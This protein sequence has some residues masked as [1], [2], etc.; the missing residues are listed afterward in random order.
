MVNDCRNEWIN[1][2]ECDG[3]VWY[4]YPVDGRDVTDPSINFT[5]T[6]RSKLKQAG[7]SR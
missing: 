1:K 5:L 4:I 2:E 3:L 7:R 6:R